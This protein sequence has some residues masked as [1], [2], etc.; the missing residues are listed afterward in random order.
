ME[1]CKN[2][3]KLSIIDYFFS[4]NSIEFS[5]L[6]NVIGYLIALPLTS[7]EQNSIGNWFELIGQ[8]ILT[9]Q[10]QNQLT[11]SGNI[12]RLELNNI[13]DSIN[14]KFEYIEEL[15]TYIKNKNS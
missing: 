8:Q 15:L 6:A 2:E 4:L 11:S 7:N 13:L 12:S 5:L 10:A 3:N 9:I 1:E 14:F